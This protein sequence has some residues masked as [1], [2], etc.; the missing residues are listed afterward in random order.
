M[1]K[2]GCLP[3]FKGIRYET[4]ADIAA[5]VE[6]PNYQYE[7]EVRGI[8]SDY[9]NT[10]EIPTFQGFKNYV[11]NLFNPSDDIKI[12]SISEIAE[13]I[14][15]KITEK[16][17]T[18][19]GLV[20]TGSVE[21]IYRPILSDKPINYTGTRQRTTNQVT[22]TGYPIKISEFPDVEFFTTNEEIT[23]NSK[24][25]STSGN[26]ITENWFLYA[27]KGNLIVPFPNYTSNNKENI[28]NSVQKLVNE[29]MNTSQLGWFGIKLVKESN[30]I[31]EWKSFKKNNPNGAIFISRGMRREKKPFYKIGNPNQTKN[32]KDGTVEEKG[33]Y[34]A[35]QFIDYILFSPS[36]GNIRALLDSGELVGKPIFYYRELGRPT[37][38]N[39]LEYLINNWEVEKQKV[40][41]KQTV[42][43]MTLE[44]QQDIIRGIT[45][46]F[47]K[48]LSQDVLNND[49][50]KIKLGVTQFIG[51]GISTG[52][53]STL[54]L[55]RGGGSTSG[56]MRI[57]FSRKK[58]ANTGQYTSKDLIFIGTDSG[59]IQSAPIFNKE[60]EFTEKYENIIDAIEAGAALLLDDVETA[61]VLRSDNDRKLA[62][63]LE[64]NT[65]YRRVGNTGMFTKEGKPF[66]PEEIKSNPLSVTKE[67]KTKDKKY[68]E[69][70]E[71]QISTE[72]KNIQEAAMAQQEA[73]AGMAEQDLSNI[74]VAIDQ[75]ED[76]ISDLYLLTGLAADE[77]F[78]ASSIEDQ[79]NFLVFNGDSNDP[80]RIEL[81][82]ALNE[83]NKLQGQAFGVAEQAAQIQQAIEPPVMKSE[84]DQSVDDMIQQLIESGVIDP[85]NQEDILTKREAIRQS[86]INATETEEV[87]SE[88]ESL[89]PQ[90]E[91]KEKRL[92]TTLSEFYKNL[93]TEEKITLNNLKENGFL[94]TKCN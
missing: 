90:E 49:I 92:K 27:R 85:T 32:L 52:L 93:S 74:K 62:Q 39:V 21:K 19:T 66:I 28:V 9:L 51:E 84:L 76:E 89:N 48:S 25:N 73:V 58:L 71:Q 38:A 87:E 65:D 22:F 63:W 50:N 4:I 6:K 35:K 33:V 44:I 34:V 3:T 37:D 10:G 79:I 40:N 16:N 26:N 88:L 24:P 77:D 29:E 20:N 8:Y 5:I 86:L 46:S 31:E 14:Y 82:Q 2:K 78:M 43:K 68:S 13:E 59:D 61:S 42:P 60:G 80:N 36:A 30:L 45:Y 57:Y 11:N 55:N 54:N 94:T 81:I 47:G 18:A 75:L 64:E 7:S 56:R 67:E 91:S 17:R 83:Y 12:N 70:T 23:P 53:D 15:S 72:I 41:I 69:E 1:S